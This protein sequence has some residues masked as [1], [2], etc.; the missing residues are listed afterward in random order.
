MARTA[1][2]TPTD[3]DVQR[4]VLRE[5]HWDT[6]LSPNEIGVAVKNGVVTL[7]GAVD[8]LYKKWAAERAAL[9]VGGVKAVVN[10]IEVRLPGDGEF[11]DRGIAEWAARVL[12]LDTLIPTNTV[13]VSVSGG[14]VTLRG[15][16]EWEYQRREAERVVRTLAGVKGVTNLIGLR[17]RNGPDPEELRTQIDEALVRSAET[18]AEK[19]T[20]TVSGDKVI[21]TGTVRS[22]AERQ[23]AERTAW[24]APGLTEVE[25]RIIIEP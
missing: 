3:E 7:T 13:K 18:D 2:T 9:H 12:E 14:W 1:T 5:L 25:N 15:E 22:W 20:V 23:E 19:I 8:S 6:Q 21:L 17:P 10:D 11:S 4:D 16:V 24:S